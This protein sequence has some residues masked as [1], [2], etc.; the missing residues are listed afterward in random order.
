V[1]TGDDEA[2]R[3]CSTGYDYEAGGAIYLEEDLSAWVYMNWRQITSDEWQHATERH[4]EL[5][6]NATRLEAGDLG[7]AEL[8]KYNRAGR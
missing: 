1:I 3:R 2:A 4:A 5:P 7:A 6:R 8:A